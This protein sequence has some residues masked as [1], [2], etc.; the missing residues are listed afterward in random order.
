MPVALKI[1]AP[2]EK[3]PRHKREKVKEKNAFTD[4]P[5]KVVQPPDSASIGKNRKIIV[6]DDS[7]VVLKA[8]EMKLKADGFAVVSLQSA[9]VVASTAEEEKAELIILDINFP[10]DSS[11]VE[12][13]G[14]TILRWLRRFP[15]LT[16]IPVILIS[17]SDSKEYT[18]KALAEGAVAFF[19]KPVVYKELLSAILSALPQAAALPPPIPR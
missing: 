5:E 16:R 18:K 4:L 2:P 8:F 17:G 19:E 13:N 15:E 1:A 12:W 6:V 14:F 9:S 11:T 3:S 10:S 7:A